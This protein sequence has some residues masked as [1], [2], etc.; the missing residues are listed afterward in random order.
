MDTYDNLIEKSK[1]AF[2]MSIEIYNKPTLRYRVEGFCFFICNAWELMLKAYLIKEKGEPSIYYKDNS[3]RTISLDNCIQ[4]IFTNAKAPLR[5]NLEKIVELRN[6]STHFITEEYEMVYIPLFQACLFNF[7]EKMQQFHRI[8]MT[9]TIPHNFLTL[10]VSVNVLDESVIRAKYPD[11]I[12]DKLMAAFNTISPMIDDNNNSFAIRIEHTYYLT[13]DKNKATSTVHIT[14]GSGTPV[15]V[16]KELKDPNDT[17]TF[18]CKTAT[19]EIGKRLKKL[20]IIEDEKMFNAYQFNLLCTYFNL[21]ENSK[22]CYTYKALAS[23]QYSY[24]MATV[25]MMVEEYKKDPNIIQEIKA[26]LKRQKS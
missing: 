13:K 20:G 11:A 24:S 2:I 12:A 14:S 1:E 4:K 8:D 10:A 6:T 3:S 23:P 26:K 15:K 19:K 5:R 21:K 25:D 16:I 22:Y 18:T 17:H 9:E 7:I